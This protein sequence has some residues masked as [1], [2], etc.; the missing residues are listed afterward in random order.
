MHKKRPTTKKSE[1]ILIYRA[2]T[3]FNM[4]FTGSKLNKHFPPHTLT[5]RKPE[6][7]L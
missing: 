7:N 2:H 1:K 4:L 3:Q 6:T 5:I